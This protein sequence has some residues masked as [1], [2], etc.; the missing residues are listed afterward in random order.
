LYQ[1]C[2][3]FTGALNTLATTQMTSYK[4]KHQDADG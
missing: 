1:V 2:R 4:S 3:H